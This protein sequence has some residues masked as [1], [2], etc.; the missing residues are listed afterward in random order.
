MKLDKR[1]QMA[2]NAYNKAIE[3][4]AVF[5]NI[6]RDLFNLHLQN[7]PIDLTYFSQFGQDKW[8]DTILNQKN[9]GYFVEL[10]ASD[11]L[12]HSNSL[13]FERLRQWKGICIDANPK[14]Y[15]DLE[16]YRKCN[17]S[18]SF[19]SNENDKKVD[20]SD[21]GLLSAAIETAG[22]FTTCNEIIKVKSKTLYSI[23]NKFKAPKVI[24]YLAIDVEGHEF[25]VLMNFP[26]NEYIFNCITI[27]HHEPNIG[28]NLRNQIKSLLESNSYIFVQSNGGGKGLGKGLGNG[29]ESGIEDFYIHKSM[30]TN[31]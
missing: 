24:D 6:L 30:N 29:M 31:T 10:G 16:K 3:D 18:N 11:G 23:L 5:I 1:K 15:K 26:F 25:H 27:N 19:I 22:P 2:E 12:Y 14:L 21:C 28:P 20:F 7:K 4:T 8:V 17:V 13:F 9:N